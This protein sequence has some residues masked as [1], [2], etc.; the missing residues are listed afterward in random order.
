MEIFHQKQGYNEKIEE[1]NDVDKLDQQLA[2]YIASMKQ[3]NGEEYSTSSIK[4][5][6]AAFYR[7]LNKNSTIKHVNIYGSNLIQI[8]LVQKNLHK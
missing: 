7:H 1:I 2:K 4:A 6:I 5:A 8:S 3:K